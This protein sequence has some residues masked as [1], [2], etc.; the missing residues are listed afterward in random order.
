ELIDLYNIADVLVTND[1]G[2]AH[3]ASLT[4]IK[5]FVF[6]GPETPK[7]YA[8]LGKNTHIFYSDFP[9]SPCLSAFNHRHT[10]CKDNKCLLV[11]S[12]EEVYQAV[13]KELAE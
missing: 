4:P 13:T 3:F 11:I 6:F 5:N 1:S 9:C 8:P 7:L 12:V 10:S 2:P